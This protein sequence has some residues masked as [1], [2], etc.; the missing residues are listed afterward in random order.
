M[1][2]NFSLINQ[3]LY[4]KKFVAAK[5]LYKKKMIEDLYP[6]FLAINGLIKVFH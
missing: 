1:T 5:D 6:I 2:K 4:F 3:R